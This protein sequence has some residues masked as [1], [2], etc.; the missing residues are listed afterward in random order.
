LGSSSRRANRSGAVDS[1]FMREMP[2]Q[3]M[4]PFPFV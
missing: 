3:L 4:F 1:S 2:S